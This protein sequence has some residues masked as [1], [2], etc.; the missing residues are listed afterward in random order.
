MLTLDWE[1]CSF[2]YQQPSWKE[3]DFFFHN[4]FSNISLQEYLQG[5]KVLACGTIWS[6]QKDFPTLADDK[7]LA[8]GDH[9]YRSAPNAITVYKWKDQKPIHFISN[10]HGVEP[11][12]A[13]R[14]L[15]K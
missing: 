5:K 1:K 3:L 2:P 4:F 7:S 15:V 13:Q 11:T 10:F 12:S 9:H 14:K 6:N 8:R